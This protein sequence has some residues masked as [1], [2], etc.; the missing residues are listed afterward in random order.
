M[1]NPN[2]PQQPA[3]QPRE[4][5]LQQIA[6]QFMAGLQRHFDMLAFNLAGRE[7]ATEENY[8][9]I[10]G[11]SG[12]MPVAQMHQNFEQMQAHARDLL[13]RTVINDILQLSVNVLNNCHLFF[14]LIKAK[15]EHGTL[16]QQNQQ[17]A[18]EA[19]QA[20]IRA[21]LTDKFDKLESDYGV[22]CELEDTFTSL[23]FALQALMQF[24]GVVQQNHLDETQL[25]QIELRCAP[26]GYSGP[27]IINP[28][29]AISRSLSFEKDQKIDFSENDLQDMLLTVAVF[30]QQLFT[31]VMKYG[32]EREG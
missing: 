13:M 19:Q 8:N 16:T 31:S 25:L 30:A 5:N 21:N 29:T 27:P 23:A 11:R 7:A 26:N 20:Y 18:H 32:Q 28:A 4:L 2:N 22:L 9:R 3:G 17:Q 14:A 1:D 10:A 15:H 12:M 24:G 6:G